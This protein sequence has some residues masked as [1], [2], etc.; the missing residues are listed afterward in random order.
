MVRRVT[1]L[2]LWAAILSG[3]GW[4]LPPLPLPVEARPPQ[5]QTGQPPVADVLE[6]A[7]GETGVAAD[8]LLSITF[9]DLLEDSRCPADI[10]CAWSGWV[11]IELRVQEANT[12]A[13]T[14]EITS[15]TDTAGKTLAP[16]G[17]GEAQPFAYY[18]NYLLEL[19]QVTPYPA[20]HAEATPLDEYR[21]VLRVRPQSAPSGTTLVA[22]RLSQASPAATPATVGSCAEELPILCR[23]YRTLVEY[24]AGVS[25]QEALQLTEPLALCT[26]TSQDAGTE[27]CIATL[28][29]GWEMADTT[30]LQPDSP[31]YEFVPVGDSFWLWD[32]QQ[33]Q[34][35]ASERTQ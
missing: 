24:T 28:G 26:L 33:D 35:R 31:W 15:F 7:Y 34:A 1:W 23:N 14:I 4:P 2:I 19:E 3:C 11:R 20:T 8:G 12:A 32:D 18:K 6:L 17:V 5:T 16:T 13:T 29:E 21:I 27:Q 30:V 9:Q 25:Q 10:L 22:T